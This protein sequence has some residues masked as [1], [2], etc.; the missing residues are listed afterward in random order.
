MWK[1]KVEKTEKPKMEK[2]QRMDVSKILIVEVLVIIVG[3]IC[4]TTMMQGLRGDMSILLDLPSFLLIMF[5]TLP[6]LFVS[7]LWRDFLKAFSINKKKYSI[8]QLRRCLEAIMITQK[9]VLISSFFSAFISIITVLKKLDDPMYI[10]PNIAVI[11]LSGFYAVIIEFLLLP[12]K[13]NAQITLINE[14]EINSEEDEMEVGN[15]E[16]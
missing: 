5:F 10:G 8:A 12:L 7:G 1:I 2:S 6:V 3:I 16:K 4:T 15:E 9:L 14:M 11:C 13:T